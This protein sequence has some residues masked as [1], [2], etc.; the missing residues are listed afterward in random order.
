MNT[1]L[2]YVNPVGANPTGVSISLERRK[3]IYQIARDYNLIIF[4]DDP[5]Y[6]LQFDQVCLHIR[7]NTGLIKFMLF[8][9]FFKRSGHR[10]FSRWML[11]VALSGLTHCQKYYLLASD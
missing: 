10:V 5:Y 6:F 9:I 11:T 2:L 7:C 4:E 3:E 1:Q 8:T